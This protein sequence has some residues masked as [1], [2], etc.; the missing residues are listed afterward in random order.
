MDLPDKCIPIANYAIDNYGIAA[1]RIHVFQ[2]SS[3]NYF[4][5]KPTNIRYE[6]RTSLC[7]ET[8][9]IRRQPTAN[10][11]P[12]TANEQRPFYFE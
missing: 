10:G 4:S 7:A 1:N 9:V 11:H 2:A 12:P 6:Q 3:V 8:T 5:P